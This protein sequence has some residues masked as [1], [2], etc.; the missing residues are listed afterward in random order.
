MTKD[1]LSYHNDPQLKK[2]ILSEM[3]IHE[4][5][6][7]L[8]K[9]SYSEKNG[10][11]KGCA[12]GC[13]VESLNLKRGFSIKH[14][15]HAGYAKALGIPEWLA[16]LEDNLFENLPENKSKKFPVNFLDAIPIGVNLEPIKWKFCAFL[17]KENIDRVLT[18]E[19]S[20]E[21][22]SE[23]VNS[24]RSVLKVHEDALKSGEWDRSAAA[25]AAE[26]T[27]SVV[28]SAA[29]SSAA[30]SAAESAAWSV[31]WAS[32]W[33]AVS[34]AESVRAAASAARVTWATDTWSDWSAP[35][36]RY[37][38]KLIELLKAEKKEELK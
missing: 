35:Y 19:I 13:G 5:Q 36:I 1:S 24:I 14:N 34:A 27:W 8:I 10:N 31:T 30:R 29:R 2:D 6:D 15:D 25:S 33:T 9:G 18:L 22:K 16:I 20:D 11:F 4:K 17:M 32:T 28:K 7:D 21:L 23:V 12:V 38:N 37:S 3:K 26:S